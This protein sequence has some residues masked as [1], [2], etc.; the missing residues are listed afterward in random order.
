MRAFHS[1]TFV[2]PLPPGHPFPMSKYRLLREAAESSMP[3]IR[4]S[5]APAASDGELALAHLPAWIEAVA[6]GTTSAAEQRE[7]DFP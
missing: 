5:E 7:I 2:L 3:G 4:V 1:D 6:Q